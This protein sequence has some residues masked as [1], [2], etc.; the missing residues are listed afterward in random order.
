MIEVKK[1]DSQGQELAIRFGL[2]GIKAVGVGMVEEMIKNRQ[3]NGGFQDIYDFASKAGSKA[4]NKKA[5]EALAKSGA[6]DNIHQGRNQIVESVETICKYAAAKEEEKNSNQ[7]SLFGA[8]QIIEE[9]PAL[10]QVADWEADKKLQ[11]EFKAF[12]F[13]L[14][15][16]PI[17]NFLEALGKRG[18]ISSENIEELNDGNIVKLAGVVAYSKH[19]SGPKGRY[20]Y[21]TLS[22]PFGIYETAI[23]DEGLITIHRDAMSDGNSLVV[24]C[25]IRKDQGGSRLLVKS[26]EK[27]EDFIKHNHPK[28]E[29]YKDIKQQEKRGEFD[30]KKRNKEKSDAKGDSVVQ[31]LEYRRRI[32]GLKNKKII[33]Q[34][35]IKIKD[36]HSVLQLKS[37][38]SQRLAPEDFEKFSKVYFLI[39]GD[40]ENL[41]KI[42][43]EGK[44]LLDE[45]DLNKIQNLVR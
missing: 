11:E 2:G 39:A 30:W 26:I 38:L 14:N 40:D 27:L 17:D 41:V 8:S 33:D 28:K 10:K 4:I 43:V 1:Y 25:L 37:F 16:H 22:D 45:N 29:I 32:D 36:R 5:L 13:F 44:Y 15:E 12:G 31:D 7:M 42:A 24:E 3:Q 34:I 19:K 6:F 23:F 21:L 35:E 20:A 18:V 9:K